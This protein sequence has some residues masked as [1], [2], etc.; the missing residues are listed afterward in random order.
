MAA[1]QFD[2]DE[3]E[4][5]RADRLGLRNGLLDLFRKT[6]S[7]PL[8]I[9]S[10]LKGASLGTI[11]PPLATIGVAVL[12]TAASGSW[13]T[14]LFGLGS[15]VASTAGA[16]SGFVFTK[17]A[18]ISRIDAALRRFNFVEESEREIRAKALH[19]P[20]VK[21]AI[22][23]VH[24]WTVG[25]GTVGALVGGVMPLWGGSGLAFGSMVFAATA[26][27]AIASNG[28]AKEVRCIAE[29][30]TSEIVTKIDRIAAKHGR[31]PATDIWFD[32][33]TI[34]AR[35]AAYAL[36]TVINKLLY[37]GAYNESARTEV[38]GQGLF[39][40]GQDRSHSG[41][42]GSRAGGGMPDTGASGD[43]PIGNK[44]G[45]GI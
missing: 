21:R 6:G 22:D 44:S 16:A 12:A 25:V 3:I 45:F 7:I 4:E 19:M 11:I 5:L 8:E 37:A 35:D 26:S 24:G 27:F 30:T 13:V 43:K 17:N 39:G 40:R 33:A 29:D 42:G 34:A 10:R 38:D 23:L 1:D 41:P 14:A 15:A 18:A 2:V 20:E 32:K 28:T 31:A 36:N 9:K